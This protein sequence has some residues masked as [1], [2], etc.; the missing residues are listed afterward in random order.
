MVIMLK[1]MKEGCIFLW[2]IGVLLI[3]LLTGRK[4]F[5]SAMPRKEQNLAKWV[6]LLM[7]IN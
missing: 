2:G 7:V 4:P 6:S 5:D 1:D 3:E